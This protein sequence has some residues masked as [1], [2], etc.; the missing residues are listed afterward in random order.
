MFSNTTKMK[1]LGILIIYVM[2]TVV[3]SETQQLTD[4]RQQKS[5]AVNALY[6]HADAATGVALLQKVADTG[7]TDANADLLFARLLGTGTSQDL[8]TVV[9][10]SALLVQDGA[11][12]AHTTQALLLAHN[13]TNQIMTKDE[14]AKEALSHYTIA[15]VGGDPIAQTIIANHYD[16][17]GDC[18]S[19]M[20]NYKKA[21]NNAIQGVY[22]DLLISVEVTPYVY[23]EDYPKGAHRPPT[24]GEVEYLANLARYGDSKAAFQVGAV[25]SSGVPGVAKDSEQAAEFL[26][27]AVKDNNTL[28]M[29]ALAN[30]QL[31][32]V[33]EPNYDE[34]LKLLRTA[35][36]YG[37][38]G[39]QTGLGRMYMYGLGGV[40]RDLQRAIF[41]LQTSI[42]HGS[43][44]AL[45]LLGVIY[46]GPDGPGEMEDAMQLWELPAKL[47]HVHSAFRLAEA[48][49]KKMEKTPVTTLKLDDFAVSELLCQKALPLYRLVAMAGEWR[50]LMEAAYLDFS[51]GLHNPA[52]LK[53]L[54]LS[55]M[56]YPEAHVNAARLIDNHIDQVYEDQSSM[57][58]QSLLTWQRAADNGLPIGQLRLG[59]LHYYGQ[60]VQQDF[61]K[62][63]GYYEKAGN[64]PVAQFNLAYMME[65]GEGTQ[66]DLKK[67]R[68][69]Y[70]TLAENH[71][72]AF[73]PTTLTIFRMD[74]YR[75]LNNTFGIDL[76]SKNFT[77]Y[78]SALIDIENG[79]IMFTVQY[80]NSVLSEWDWLLMILLS[81]FI[82]RM[83]TLRRNN[84]Q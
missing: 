24:P 65:W 15:S 11:A 69:L 10:D 1:L 22:E 28:A 83:L 64:L 66:L 25:L 30:L 36:Q 3:R 31:R 27:Q 77:E 4:W 63:I 80:V 78:A 37:E 76:Y 20:Y 14:L 29:V 46:D 75:Q 60:G 71:E 21:A 35:F 49:R 67:A 74:V 62:A 6:R 68:T 19:A 56:G 34:A 40:R 18:D 26:Q 53:Y 7:D 57:A 84:N 38:M 43:L 72:E 23:E 54:L 9:K 58:T 70:E 81:V 42:T 55:D 32:G 61:K 17:M 51:S 48:Y 82:F 5:Y 16:K 73:I 45:Y 44:E 41:H 50:H 39:A 12:R 52:L 8:N 47:G 2:C 79:E 33:I 59:D 13:L